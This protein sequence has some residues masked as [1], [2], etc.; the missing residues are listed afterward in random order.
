MNT[1]FS[2]ILKQPHITEKST[3]SAENSVYVFEINPEASKQLVTKAFAEKYKVTPV[4]VR[5]VTIPAK[6]VFVRGK[7]GLKSGYKKA[8][9]YLKKGEKIEII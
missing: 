6:Q 9:I 2:Y 3:F 8:Y 5:T 4:K 1:H 7:K